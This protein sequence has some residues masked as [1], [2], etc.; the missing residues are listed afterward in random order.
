MKEK[1]YWKY[2]SKWG[3]M[4]ISFNTEGVLTGLWFT[5]QKHFKGIDLYDLQSPDS[6]MIDIKVMEARGVLFDQLRDYEKGKLKEFSI[7]I[8]PDG[9][10]F[11]K[12][13]WKI[14][15]TIP[16]GKTMTYGEISRRIASVLKKETMSAQAVGQA[17]GRNPISIVIP[18]HRV[19]GK[20]GQLTG[21]AGGIHRKKALLH[22]ESGIIW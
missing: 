11:Q 21:Y 18:C 14:L 12:E 10:E 16:Y 6:M 15:L 2:E 3:E 9:T 17:V 8:D 5:G 13:V 22:L 1:L 7:L 4:I 19:V 20:K